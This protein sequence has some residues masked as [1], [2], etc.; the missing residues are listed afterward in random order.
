VSEADQI[1]VVPEAAGD[2]TRADRF[3]VD[4][5]ASR[6]AKLMQVSTSVVMLAIIGWALA[7][8]PRS[9]ITWSAAFFIAAAA[10][11]DLI[12]V[13]AWGGMQLSLSFPILVGVAMLFQPG[14]A[15]GVSVL[16]YAD[17]R[18]FRHEVTVLRAIWNRAQMALG[19]L[20]ASW[21]FHRI[22]TA[23]SP[24]PKLITAAAAATLVA[25]AINTLAVAADASIEKRMPVREVLTKMHGVH[26]FEFLFSYLGLGL[27]G[28][29]IARFYLVEG[30]WSV[31]VFL[32]PLVFARQ[33]YFRSRALADQLVEQNELL[34]RQANRLE[35]LL[36]KEHAA[37]DELT[38][39]NRMKGEFVAVVSHELRTPVTSLIGYAKTLRLPEFAEDPGMRE[40]FLERM[41]RQGDRLLLLVENLLTAARLESDQLQ[42]SIGRVLFE[43]LCREIV[44]GLASEASRVR[45]DVPS[46]LP[47]I[48]TDRQLLGRIVSNLL[49][50]ALKYSP[51]GTPCELGARTDGEAIE[52]WVRDH[53]IG[54]PPEEVGRIFERFYQVDSSTTRMFRGAGLGLSMVRDLLVRMGGTIDVTS[55]PSEGSTF[56][57]KLP[58]VATVAEPQSP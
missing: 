20:A 43:D 21:L 52:F 25:Y 5:Q 27:F 11:V 24:W 2:G 55:T 23:S 37:V 54:I 16:G 35:Q 34:E 7:V 40:E 30:A 19:I 47:V 17:P 41:E 39:L 32:A 38:Q 31:V 58:V 10:I 56:T 42:I 28:T 57:V 4:P 26:P 18:E 3:A 1:V 12:P 9:D 45:L 36:R 8:T 13:P 48:H 33:M 15:A 14:V 6:R 22:A 53:G 50:N 29:A 51:P 44:E 49:D 46:D